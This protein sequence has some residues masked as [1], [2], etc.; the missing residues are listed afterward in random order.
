MN[1]HD[2]TLIIKFGGA[3]ASTPG[4]FA[5]L[6]DLILRRASEYKHIVVV[7]SAMEGVTDQLIA[8]AKQVHPNPPQREYDMLLTC[9][10]RISMSLLAMALTLKSNQA[11][12]LTGSQAG[13]ITSSRHTE[14]RILEVRPQRIISLLRQGKIVIVAG[15]QG[16]SREGEITTLGRGGS[17]TTAVALALALHAER[18]EFYKDVAGIYSED[19]KKAKEASL[20]DRL[21]Y[22]EALDIA[23]KGAKV[24][25]PRAITL[26]KR[27]NI[28]LLVRSF[29][30]EHYGKCPGTLIEGLGR[31][32]TTLY[33]EN[34]EDEHPAAMQQQE[35]SERIVMGV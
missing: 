2:K 17:D 27:N 21:S 16:V 3:S 7:I 8:L 35:Q 30:E 33:Y 14:A 15:F 5:H 9:G 10:E 28:P 6:S 18:V 23:Y 1:L 22:D 24:L 13:I 12:S 31:R 19:P 32:S 4:S 11:F 26:A 34:T 25:H 20:Y 29:Q